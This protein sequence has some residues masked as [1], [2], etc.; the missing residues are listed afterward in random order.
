MVLFWCLVS[1][2]RFVTLLSMEQRDSAIVFEE[3]WRALVT[4]LVATRTLRTP[5]I[6]DAFQKVPRYQ[7]VPAGSQ[8]GAASLD[9]ALPI[10]EGQ[11]VSQ[12]TTVA[13]MLELLKP[14]RGERVLDVG[15][16]SGWQA[17]L[18]GHLVGPEGRVYSVERLPFLAQEA[19]ERLARLGHANVDVLLGDATRGLPEHAP[20]D[21]IAVAAESARVPAVFLEELANGGRLLQ[22]ISGAGLRVLR[23]DASGA[24]RAEGIPGFVFVPLVESGETPKNVPE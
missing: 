24:V 8:K 7:F 1:G 23:K 2:S 6:I 21:V 9:A 20:Y 12:P 14:R 5:R 15:T 3:A 10:G 22:P 18:L 13:I 19:R 16:G 11:T 4:S 17:A